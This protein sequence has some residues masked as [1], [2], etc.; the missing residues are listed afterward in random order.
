MN[1][2]DETR[3]EPGL[4]VKKYN[5]ADYNLIQKAR[6]ALQYLSPNVPHDEW[7]QI[8]MAAKAA[9]LTLDEWDDWS[10]GGDSY[11]QSDARAAWRGFDAV[12][13]ISAGTLFYLAKTEGWSSSLTARKS[14]TKLCRKPAE[15]PKALQL[16][17]G[18]LEVWGRCKPATAEHGYIAA[19]GGTP[20]GL[21][22]V[23][24]GDTLTIASQQMAGALVVPV[25]PLAGGEP[26]SLQFI[27]PPGGGK[28]LNLPNALMDGIFT[29]GQAA[30]EK[31][32]TKYIVEGIGQ[33][34]ACSSA[35]GNSAVVCFGS[36]RMRNVAAELRQ[37][38]ATVR[39]VVV[40]D[41]GKE[42]YAEAIAAEVDGQYVVMPDGWKE[43]DD[44]NDLARLKGLP[45]LK[46]LLATAIAPAPRKSH[47]LT[48]F[49]SLGG[50]PKVPTWVIPGF[51]ESGV[52]M[53]AGTHGVGK[54]TAL[55]PLTMVA[56]GLHRVGDPLAPR[57]WRHIVYVTE[58]VEQAKRILFGIVDFNNLSLITVRERFHI[59]N[60]CR[61]NPDDVAKASATYKE[62][63][64][65]QIL[66]VEVLPLVVFDTKSA[67]F[68]MD[69]E[70][71][72]S[73]A[74]KIVAILKQDFN[75]LPVWLI[76][77][78]AKTNANQTNPAAISSRGGGAFDADA[79]QC[80]YLVEEKGI[81]YLKRGKTRFE[82][83]WPELV[84]NSFSETMM[85]SNEFGDQEL[86]TLR[87]AIAS[88][89]ERSRH[90][91]AERYEAQAL[92]RN[93]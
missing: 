65:R 80:L 74:S 2:K 66:G 59:V 83:K 42:A 38:D 91:D 33:A 37:Q 53:I 76:G 63:F 81:R 41:V 70:N 4:L 43:N 14:Q 55:L 30:A 16:G 60:A 61:M 11:K 78:V 40:P 6:S 75:G 90:E 54:T 57:H 20:D 35:T 28:K 10:S 1:E 56:A 46:E 52:V 73:E 12:G 48:Q 9:G 71:S 79:N 15:P 17:K 25:I 82:A 13:G 64:S 93:K 3:R 7:V 24:E 32:T 72:N 77:H 69:D 88:P 29:V 31:S 23:P 5:Q 21:R 87:W 19:K 49:I 85:A 62:T 68:S 27:P 8:G 34:W 58:D 92:L 50:K 84:I 45:A 44:V 39:L 18:A 51:I 26:V 22:V 89:S 86:I 36:G 67:V 47:P